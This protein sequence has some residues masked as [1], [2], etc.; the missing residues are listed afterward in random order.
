MY[1]S[2]YEYLNLAASGKGRPQ[3]ANMSITVL[4]GT[5]LFWSK[6]KSWLCRRRKTEQKTAQ[7]HNL[8]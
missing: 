1:A 4:F 7:E 5:S 2:M 3:T 8:R 6:E